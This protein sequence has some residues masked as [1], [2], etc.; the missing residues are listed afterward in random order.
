MVARSANG[1]SS[2]SDISDVHIYG[3]GAKDSI[4]VL[5][6]SHLNESMITENECCY[7]KYLRG[8]VH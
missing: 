1:G 3:D 8:G 4:G 6:E 2:N 7:R 5:I